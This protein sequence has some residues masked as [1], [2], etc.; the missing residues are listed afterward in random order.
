[1]GESAQMA[2]MD[3]TI[4]GIYVVFNISPALIS[5]PFSLFN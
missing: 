3:S 2:G 5:M 1:M 4:H